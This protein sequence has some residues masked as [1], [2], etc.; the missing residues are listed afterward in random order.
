LS[1]RPP[2]LDFWTGTRPGCGGRVP[3]HCPISIL[4]AHGGGAL[5]GFALSTIDRFVRVSSQPAVEQPPGAC[6]TLSPC[7][8]STKHAPGS[9]RRTTPQAARTMQRGPRPDTYSVPSTSGS[10]AG[11][12]RYEH[13]RAKHAMQGQ[14]KPAPG[15]GAWARFHRH[16]IASGIASLGKEGPRLN[17]L[18]A[19]PHTPPVAPGSTHIRVTAALLP[20][21]AGQPLKAVWALVVEDVA[22]D[23]SHT[24][25]MNE[26]ERRHRHRS[27]ARS[28]PQRMR[29]HPPD[30][31]SSVPGG[32]K[33][34]GSSAPPSTAGAVAP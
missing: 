6:C 33:K 16:W 10:Q 7:C 21:R 31:A 22:A 15:K 2:D 32:R 19:A 3:E 9:T 1:A 20:A 8:S 29:R 24:A 14:P 12:V 5:P 25:R 30:L 26:G 18:S 13:D 28:R 27:H 34:R 17:L 23:G 4:Q 11:R